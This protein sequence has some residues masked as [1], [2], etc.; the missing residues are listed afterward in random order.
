MD[1][2]DSPADLEYR[3]RAAQWLAQNAPSHEEP[4]SGRL[5]VFGMRTADESAA[6]VRAAMAWQ[7]RKYT[8]GWA[9]IGIPKSYGGSGGAVTEALLFT[10]EESRYRMPLDAESITQG[11]VVPTLAQWA[12]PGQRER[13]LMPIISGQQLSCQMFSEPDAGSDLAAVR[14]SARRTSDGWVV[15]GQ[16]IWTSYAQYASFGYLLARTGEGPRHHGLTAFLIDLEQLGVRVRPIRQ[17]TGAQTFNEVFFDDAIVEPDAI[18]GE[19]G[20]GWAVALSTLMAERYSLEPE[21]VGAD[22]LVKLL[23]GLQPTDENIR[24]RAA[25]VITMQHVLSILKLRLRS[26]AA[27]GLPPGPEGSITKLLTTIGQQLAAETAIDALCAD[28]LRQNR[29]SELLT[30]AL[31][32][33]VG[34]GT[35]EIMR[36]VIAERV[37]SLPRDPFVAPQKDPQNDQRNNA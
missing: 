14:T 5:S 35:D 31:G 37:L 9:G 12:T 13:Y 17:A 23:R 15:N 33:R 22:A 28:G 32:L 36:N 16:K 11:M 29:W 6:H 19:P 10:E 18:L 7:A 3:A 4:A 8:D 24:R 34:G 21:A 30:G 27:A 2:D 20:Q 1:F 26:A 25:D